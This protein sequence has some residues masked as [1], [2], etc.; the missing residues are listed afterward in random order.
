MSNTNISGFI[1]DGIAGTGKTSALNVYLKNA[2]E[3]DHLSNIILSEHQTLR[4]LEY[5]K[6]KSTQ[7]SQNLLNTHVTYLE[8]LKHHLDKSDWL[9]RDRNAQKVSFILERFHF[10]HIYHFDHV[11]WQDVEEIDNRLKRLNT[12]LYLFTI[13]PSDIKSRIIDDYKKS[14]WGDYLKTLGSSEDEIIDYFTKKQDLMLKLA[15]KTKLE[16]IIV[17]TSKLSPN[18]AANKLI[19]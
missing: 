2:P 1:I 5:E 4:V 8:N 7:T 10:S 19:T 17:N 15:D 6:D 16:V 14:G 3:K 13:K 18:Q 12:K 9:K 11:D